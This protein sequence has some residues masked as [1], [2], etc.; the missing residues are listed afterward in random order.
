M[1]EACIGYVHVLPRCGHWDSIVVITCRLGVHDIDD[2]L[3]IH[4][5]DA[6]ACATLDGCL[7]GD[8]CYKQISQNILLVTLI[9]VDSHHCA[10]QER[11]SPCLLV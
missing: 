6:R 1:V 4:L 3:V 7:N 8:H 5:T 11:V 9:V 2:W 10:E